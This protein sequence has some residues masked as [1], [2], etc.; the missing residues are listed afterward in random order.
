MEAKAG[1]AVL[2]GLVPIKERV[3]PSPK[4]MRGIEPLC[5]ALQGHTLALHGQ[6]LLGEPLSSPP[7]LATGVYHSVSNERH[8]GMDAISLRLR[9]FSGLSPVSY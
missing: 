3:A 9:S 7:R 5:C 6:M 1:E 8:Y 4:P 2:S